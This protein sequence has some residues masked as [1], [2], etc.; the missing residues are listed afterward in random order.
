MVVSYRPRSSAGSHAVAAI[1]PQRCIG[2]SGRGQYGEQYRLTRADERIANRAAG[3]HLG[4]R[5][6]SDVDADSYRNDGDVR[7]SDGQREA[8][9]RDAIF[10]GI[11]QSKIE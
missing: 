3:F 10:R 7:Q 11:V 2:Q 5:N 9:L 4:E 8:P 1:R 6:V